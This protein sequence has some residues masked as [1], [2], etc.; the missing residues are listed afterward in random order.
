M[1]PRSIC[2]IHL[3]VF[4]VRRRIAV[5]LHCFGDCPVDKAAHTFTVIFCVSLHCV[6]SFSVH[7]HTSNRKTLHVFLLRFLLRFRL[8]TQE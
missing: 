7:P 3:L 6:I 4:G 5:P 8:F 1:V 2:R